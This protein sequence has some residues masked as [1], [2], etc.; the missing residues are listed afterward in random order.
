LGVQKAISRSDLKKT[1]KGKGP[2][3]PRL[4]ENRWFQRGGKVPGRA[5][6]SSATQ[7]KKKE[8]KNLREKGEPWRTRKGEE[9]PFFQLTVG[10]KGRK[11]KREQRHRMGHPGGGK[12]VDPAL[13]QNRCR[14]KESEKCLT[15]IGNRK[16]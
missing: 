9:S 10:G 12:S 11:H 3:A 13:T 7:R 15:K 8:M 14:Q 16:N 2:P 4:G 5:M 1:F 6:G